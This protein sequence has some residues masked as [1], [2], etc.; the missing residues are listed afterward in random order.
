VPLRAE[1]SNPRLRVLPGQFVKVQVVAGQARAFLVPQAA[2]IQ[3]EQGRM[4][5]VVRDGQ[6]Q[7]API[8]TAGWSGSDWVVTSGLKA[9]DQVIVD[10]LMKLRPGAPVNA[11]APAASAP[12]ASAAAVSAPAS[13]N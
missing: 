9:G 4:V 12:A 10:N 6:A 3:N 11:Q 7:P 8:Q 13:G 5:W 2:V 1:F